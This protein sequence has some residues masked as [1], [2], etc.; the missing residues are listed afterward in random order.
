MSKYDPR[1]PALSLQSST[2]KPELIGIDEFFPLAQTHAHKPR[3]YRR[4]EKYFAESLMSSSFQETIV[5]TVPLTAAGGL[6]VCKQSVYI[7]LNLRMQF[8]SNPVPYV[9]LKYQSK[10]MERARRIRPTRQVIDNSTA[11]RYSTVSVGEPNNS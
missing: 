9:C 3:W 10:M 8:D 4:A 11:V 2:A 1:C 5:N 6:N 7:I